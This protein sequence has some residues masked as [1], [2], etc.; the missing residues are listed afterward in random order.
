MTSPER[1]DSNPTR[2]E[3]N[4]EQQTALEKLRQGETAALLEFASSTFPKTE[5]RRAGRIAKLITLFTL[6]STLALKEYDPNAPASPE[7]AELA[8]L[9]GK[10]FSQPA[11][12]TE[13]DALTKE[14]IKNV[15]E[16]SET[17]YVGPLIFGNVT[18]YDDGGSFDGKKKTKASAKNNL[19]GEL[20]EQGG[21]VVVRGGSMTAMNEG[22]TNKVA[23]INSSTRSAFALSG[24]A[25]GFDVVPVGE[26][27]DFKGF[28][29]SAKDALQNGLEGAASFFG[30]NITSDTSLETKTTDS[31]K[32]VRFTENLNEHIQSL[33][34]QPFHSYELAESKKRPD[35]M[36]EVTLRVQP[37]RVIETDEPEKEIIVEKPKG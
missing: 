5:R 7:S 23:S 20:P 24:I 2:P 28:G 11:S 25:V 32:G 15:I 26:K 29:T 9:V 18:A 34:G 12:Q 35:G 17:K 27:L 1:L 36:W 21:K 10:N 31:K 3:H 37:G 4:A 13:L 30:N 16:N 22:V 6:A 8:A 33:Y 14:L 19:R